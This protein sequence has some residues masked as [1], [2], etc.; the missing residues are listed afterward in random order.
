MLT[1]TRKSESAEHRGAGGGQGP[2]RAGGQ[3]RR[4]PA[5]PQCEGPGRHHHHLEDLRDERLHPGCAPVPTLSNLL[6]PPPIS[7]YNATCQSE[8]WVWVCVCVGGCVCVCVWRG[9][10]RLVAATLATS[11][12][13]DRGARSHPAAVPVRLPNKRALLTAR[14]CAGATEDDDLVEQALAEQFTNTFDGKQ[15]TSAA[16]APCPPPPRPQPPMQQRPTAAD[17]D[18]LPPP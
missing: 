7:H 2:D 8:V 10:G 13:A 9:G 1:P 12:R 6:A 3:G 4:L 16:T 15:V 14:R 17:A 18:T 5:L 11:L